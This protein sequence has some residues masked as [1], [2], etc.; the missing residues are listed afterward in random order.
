MISLEPQLVNG[1][2]VYTIVFSSNAPNPGNFDG[3]EG[4][5][6][7][8]GNSEIW[9]Y[10]LPA[11]SDVD[12]TLGTDL[13]LIDLSAGTFVQITNTPASRL[14]AA[15]SATLSPFFADDNREP[16]LTDDGQLL[17]FISTRNLDPG[18]GNADG[19]PELFFYNVQT[20]SFRQGTNTQDA[21]AGIGLVFQ[22]NPNLSSDGSVVAF[23]SS[24]NLAGNNND[25]NGTGNA[26]IYVANFTGAGLSNIRQVTRTKTNATTPANVNVWSPGRRLSRN[27]A[28]LAFESLANDPKANT[29][30]LLEWNRDGRA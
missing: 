27:G 18:I 17:A 30:T 29:D 22:S 15:G 11:V 8:D 28:V 4:N 21:V 14:P 2:R 23:L 10:R 26:E 13:P 3:T 6:A 20:Q 1:Q 5:L 7:Q 24:A 12:L 16:T 25:S 9:I 19:N